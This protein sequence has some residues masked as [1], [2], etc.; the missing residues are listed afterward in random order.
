MSYVQPMPPAKA[1]TS[2]LT[3]VGGAVLLGAAVYAASKLYAEVDDNVVSRIKRKAE[4]FADSESESE[5]EDAPSPVHQDDDDTPDVEADAVKEAVDKKLEK[6]VRPAAK[7][8]TAPGMS[9]GVPMLDNAAGATRGVTLGQSQPPVPVRD[10]SV[11]VRGINLN[12]NAVFKPATSQHTGPVA[13]MAAR[14]GSG[15]TLRPP[16]MGGAGWTDHVAHLSSV[17]RNMTRDLR[18]DLPVPIPTD[19]EPVT[20]SLPAFGPAIAVKKDVRG[21]VEIYPDQQPSQA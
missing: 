2:A 17:K 10:G 18:G 13:Y 1:K 20:G 8:S 19:G 12:S 6:P 15:Q 5:A 11:Q 4:E 9:G 16:V 14:E 3:Y 7:V 21:V